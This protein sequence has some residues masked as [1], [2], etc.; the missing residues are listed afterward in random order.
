MSKEQLNWHRYIQNKFKEHAC[1]TEVIVNNTKFKTYRKCD[2]LNS[3]K[4]VLEIQHS[5][6]SKREIGNRIQD[7]IGQRHPKV[8]WLID[9]RKFSIIERTDDK[10][11]LITLSYPW[12]D[13]SIL[14]SSCDFIFAYLKIDTKE[15]I[16][17]FD[18]SSVRNGM[19][20]VSPSY[21]YSLEHFIHRFSYN[22]STIFYDSPKPF[23]SCRLFLYVQ[24]P[25]SGKTFGMV[26]RVLKPSKHEDFR[27]YE[28]F[29]ILTKP[30]SA[31]DVVIRNFKEQLDNNKMIY[32]SGEENRACWFLVK[33]DGKEKL[34]ILATGDSF[35]FRLGEKDDRYLDLF[36]GICR[37]IETRGPTK[38][39]VR[40]SVSFKGHSFKINAQ[41]LI[42]CDEATKFDLHY[43][44]T[45]GKIMFYC[46]ADACLLGD[47]LQSIEYENNMLTHL[48][49]T[50][51][52]FPH[53]EKIV[54][55][56]NEI[57]R[58]GDNLVNF[59]TTIIGLD[60]YEKYNLRKPIPCVDKTI[61]RDNEGDI[62]IMFLDMKSTNE[63]KKLHSA[64]KTILKKLNY[65]IN[66]LYLLP[67]DILIV[68]PFVSNNPFGDHLR[69]SIDDFWI[70][71]LDD[72]S[73]RE[74]MLKSSYKDNAVKFFKMFDSEK[75]KKKIYKRQYQ[76]IGEQYRWMAFF[77]RSE[78]GNPINTSDSDNATRMVSIHAA[79]G[80]GR[81]LVFTCQLSE[82]A[83]K[84]FSNGKKNLI[85]DSLLNVACSRAKSKL[86][87]ALQIGYS[88]D[89]I[90]KFKPYFTPQQSSNIVPKLSITSLFYIRNPLYESYGKITDKEWIQSM[91]NVD[92]KSNYK[93]DIIEYEH[94]VIRK[95]TF[96][97]TLTLCIYS[98]EISKINN[99][100]IFTVLRKIYN[101]EIK[102]V[103]ISEYYKILNDNDELSCIPL[104]LYNGKDE[105]C[106]AI[107]DLCLN[108]KR[109]ILSKVQ[110]HKNI[111]IKDINPLQCV[112]L[113]YMIEIFEKKKYSL[114]KMNTLID[115]YWYCSFKCSSDLTKHYKCIDRASAVFDEIR[116]NLPM[117]DD[118]RWNF[119][120]KISL[121][122]R[123]GTYP[124]NF[125][126]RLEIPFIYTTDNYCI[127][128]HI[129]PNMSSLRIDEMATLVSYAG[130]FMS[131]P[132][133]NNNNTYKISGKNK[134]RFDGKQIQIYISSIE[135]SD[136]KIQVFNWEDLKKYRDNMINV[137]CDYVFQV[138]F[139]QH[140][141]IMEFIKYYKDRS[142]N[143][144]ETQC[145]KSEY[146]NYML[147]RY[148]DDFE[149]NKENISK[150]NENFK[151]KLDKKLE[152]TVKLFKNS[153]NDS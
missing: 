31:K 8:H 7:Y 130:L 137:L 67:N 43:A 18:P 152:D 135:E 20:Y 69:D 108:V 68:F 120:H 1:D 128:I 91:F 102:Q 148:C 109:D 150:Y 77:H 80:D 144:F 153:L 111:D 33:I 93:H 48:I 94:H 113:W 25:G 92:N 85:Y 15:F 125:K 27:Q 63:E 105:I 54:K 49:D 36:K 26:D 79:Q 57:R 14:F 21:K 116:K 82:S 41:T 51:D 141:N 37:T 104:I 19:V 59:L 89:V 47:K 90:D 16:V 56:G 145:R 40:G 58:F 32:E 106:N 81:R 142:H 9:G 72:T 126:C 143:E 50:D 28:S 103:D 119:N 133:Q 86:I 45:I 98:K 46:M 88:D 132:F 29:I 112:L 24:P 12:L 121:G 84:K 61:Q 110:D 76:N 71:K 74:F 100:Q 5:A 107:F 129:L 115:I 30:H 87:M 6:I 64:V 134:D 124:K 17:K 131:Q 78:G 117:D 122:K 139:S 149:E 123:D 34:I 101:L 60:T 146:V 140:E 3:K 151:G 118:S 147:E 95:C 97:L 65:E 136:K 138:C 127:A 96:H 75:D 10:R 23:R 66:S 83:L 39:G 38:L 42:I 53:V 55:E 114:L 13:I 99:P 4:L 62:E 2:V 70:K 44:N 22:D 35:I 52:P 11:L 73:Y